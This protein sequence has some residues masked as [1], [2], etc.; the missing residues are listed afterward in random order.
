MKQNKELLRSLER[1]STT[2]PLSASGKLTI[3][4]VAQK[5][6]QPHA[7]KPI[8]INQ[9]SEETITEL[10]NLRL[11]DVQPRFAKHACQKTPASIVRLSRKGEEI[12]QQIQSGLRSAQRNRYW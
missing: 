5:Q 3:L 6:N 2:I 8:C 1:L 9:L 10:L 12:A 7:C 11:I 4:K